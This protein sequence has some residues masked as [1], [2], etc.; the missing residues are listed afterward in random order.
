ML[1]DRTPTREVGTPP[2]SLERAL[3]IPVAGTRPG[4]ARLRRGW[5][6]GARDEGR[7]MRQVARIR[8]PALERGHAPLG[9]PTGGQVPPRPS[10]D[11]LA[12]PRELTLHLI[13]LDVGPSR[14]FEPVP[15]LGRRS[16][17]PPPSLSKVSPPHTIRTHSHLFRAEAEFQSQI[18]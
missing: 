4:R 14:A 2:R 17:D 7:R 15:H 8:S 1:R 5:A 18:M 12:K 10:V 6:E 3:E 13:G 11:R 16:Y 9:D